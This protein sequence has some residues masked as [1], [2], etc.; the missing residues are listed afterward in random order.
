M[1]SYLVAVF[2]FDIE[3][4]VLAAL[5]LFSS[6]QFAALYRHIYGYRRN[7]VKTIMQV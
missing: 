4:F 1:L 6:V 2:N 3:L 7:P 5:S